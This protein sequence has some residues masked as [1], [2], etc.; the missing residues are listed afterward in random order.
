ALGTL[1][2]AERL[3][4]PPVHTGH[5]PVPRELHADRGDTDGG[6]CNA[7]QV[8]ALGYVPPDG[9]ASLGECTDP[10][11]FSGVSG[12]GRLG[13]YPGAERPALADPAEDDGIRCAT[14]RSLHVPLARRRVRLHELLPGDS[15]R[16]PPP[17]VEDVIASASPGTGGAE[18]R[19]GSG[20][21]GGI[22]SPH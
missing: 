19:V 17:P 9:G 3:R 12:A 5:G 2:P 7:A 11:G 15:R 4:L 1:S 16:L 21:W 8:A 13:P 22:P 18:E 20:R 6:P 10:V 14:Q